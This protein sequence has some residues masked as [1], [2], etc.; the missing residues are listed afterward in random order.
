LL[1]AADG[2]ILGRG[3]AASSNYQKVGFK[4]AT[5]AII[6]GIAAAFVDGGLALSAPAAICLGLAGVDTE[7]DGR[8]FRDWLGRT[9]P[10]SQGN[11]VNDAELALAAGTPDGTGVALICGTGAIAVGRN[12]QGEMARADGWGYL[13]GD[14]GSGFAIGQDAMRHV[15]RELDGRGPA[16]RLTVAI[17]GHWGL[18]S[19]EALLDYVYLQEASPATIASLAAVV[20]SVAEQGDAV[21]LE[22]LR[23]AASEVAQTIHAVV[24]RLGLNDGGIAAP[25]ALAGSVVTRSRLVSGF[26]LAAAAARGLLLEPVT[27]V[28]EPVLGAIRLAAR[29][30]AR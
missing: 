3:T 6:D 7:E 18:A 10:L 29:Q 28:T 9:F 19:P 23:A 14:D 5:A 30:M 24:Q 4:S 1:A 12:A 17:L 21:A 16:T 11:V 27:P 22:I 2:T 25:C 26:L 20:N 15:L 13:L 8:R